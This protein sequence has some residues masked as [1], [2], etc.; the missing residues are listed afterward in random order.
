MSTTAEI[1]TAELISRT[2]VVYFAISKLIAPFTRAGVILIKF[3]I[4]WRTF[5]TVFC[6]RLIVIFSPYNHCSQLSDHN[7]SEFTAVCVDLYV[8]PECG[9]LGLF[10]YIKF[11]LPRQ[12]T[13]SKST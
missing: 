9:S 11:S 5:P 3:E 1:E 12:I 13:I 8:E 4:A 7:E 6:C 10:A 2:I